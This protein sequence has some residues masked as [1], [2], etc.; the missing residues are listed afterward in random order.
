MK[1][2][3]AVIGITYLISQA[4]AAYLG[5]AATLASVIIIALLG[6]LYYSFNGKRNKAVLT[7]VVTACIAM[8]IS[9][10]Y[11]KLFVESAIPLE[12]ETVYIKG[13]IVEE[14]YSQY[15]RYYYIIKTEQIG[16]EGARQKSKIRISSKDSL[17]AQY[18][19]NIEGE[20][21]FTVVSNENSY[22]S[23]MHLLSKGITS[24]A[25]VSDVNSITVSSGE[26]SLYRYAIIMRNKLKSTIKKLYP[27]ETGDVLIAM[28][29]GEESGIDN[30]TLKGFRNIGIAHILAVSGLH[31]S[32]L[33]YAVTW[34]LRRLYVNRKVIAVIVFF[35]SWAYAAIAGFPMSS[36]RAALMITVMLLGIIVDRLHTPLNSL[37]IALLVICLFEPYAAVDAGLLMS[38]SSTFG[39]ITAA[40]E[41]N[42]YVQRVIF[43]DKSSIY[44]GV[45]RKTVSLLVCSFTASIFIMPVSVLL[46]GK[47]SLLS[48]I[49]NLLLIPIAELFLGV[50]MIAAFI[51]SFGSIGQ[52]IAYPFMAVDWIIGKILLI[53]VNVFDNI[54]GAILNTGSR[55]E[56]VV[57]GCILIG[58]LWAVLFYRSKFRKIAFLFCAFCCI[59][60]TFVWYFC[61]YMMTDSKTI[62]V[63]NTGNTSI[64]L[65]RD[66][67]STVLIGAGGEDYKVSLAQYD[68]H[69]KGISEITALIL[70][71]LSQS[72]AC[73]ADT[74]IEEMN[75]GEVFVSGSGAYYDTVRYVSQKN[76]IEISDALNVSVSTGA[77]NVSTL[78][79]SSEK[80]WSLITCGDMTAVI[81]PDGGNALDCPFGYEFDAVLMHGEIPSCIAS[82]KA[83]VYILSAEYDDGAIAV[84]QLRARGLKNVY[85]TGTDGN[86]ELSVRDGRLYIGGENL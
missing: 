6:V 78:S 23:K 81:C 63:Y 2:P 71:D 46:F 59:V 82:F 72:G 85:C 19:D 48:P 77:V 84:S 30:N 74:I 34:I 10:G 41:L 43:K 29:T 83:K 33:A 76:T 53:A 79:D 58:I 16:F 7:A 25:Y 42:R 12:G 54:P 32:L 60:I 50:G 31:L 37:G 14:P 47:V 36:L 13:Q 51:G 20:V 61:G 3:F 57:L 69:S 67:Q 73:C 9:F 70:T 24:S 75:P 44:V 56:I 5:T 18:S 80:L 28:M 64:V 22:A 11:T 26:A 52:L 17:E 27:D 55:T 15:G 66:R 39:L 8:I 35:V 62:T 38:F 68:M 86:M 21:T 1:R 65:A 40:P 49:A 4:V 45:L